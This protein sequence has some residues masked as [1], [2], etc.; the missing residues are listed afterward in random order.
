[1]VDEVEVEDDPPG[2][3]REEE[4]EREIEP[5]GSHGFSHTDTCLVL[6]AVKGERSQSVHRSRSSSPA[7]RA[8]RSN[9]PGETDLNGIESL[10]QR[11]STRLKWCETRCWVAGSNSSMPTWLSLRS[12]T[13]SRAVLGT[14]TSTTKQ[15]PGS[16]CAAAFANVDLSLLRGLV[17]DRVEDDVHE[18]ESPVDARRRVV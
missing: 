13:S 9:S 15:P 18:R 14:P 3:H 16:R 10:V 4:L 6:S 7:S 17:A 1:H 5:A 12:K 2:P 11:P 8:I